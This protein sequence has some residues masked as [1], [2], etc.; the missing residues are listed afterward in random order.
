VQPIWDG[1]KYDQV[2][3]SRHSTLGDELTA[4]DRG[5]KRFVVS[6]SGKIPM[7]IRLCNFPMHRHGRGA[8]SGTPI[9]TSYLCFF[10]TSFTHGCAGIYNVQF[11]RKF[12][13]RDMWVLPRNNYT[14]IFLEIVYSDARFLI[15]FCALGASLKFDF[16]D[17][18][19]MELGSLK[20]DKI[21]LQCKLTK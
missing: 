2:S 15:R 4:V 9:I 6:N 17:S 13:N 5:W 14:Q 3:F 7:T 8:P 11:S 1:R 10:A 20:Q 21:E 19:I 16:K 12:I 18:R